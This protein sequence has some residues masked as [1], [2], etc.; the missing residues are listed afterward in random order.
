MLMHRNGIRQTLL[1]LL[2]L[3]GIRAMHAPE[4]FGAVIL[5][6]GGVLQCQV[7]LPGWAFQ[8]RDHLRPGAP[9]PA[10]DPPGK[11]ARPRSA[12][13]P[14]ARAHRGGLTA[15][16]QEPP[17]VRAPPPRARSSFPNPR[18]AS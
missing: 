1:G 15:H 6:R 18:V 8:V 14:R 5:R 3:P 2:P 13:A 9:L 11:T 7:A 4:V 10:R 17:S 12:P 16:A